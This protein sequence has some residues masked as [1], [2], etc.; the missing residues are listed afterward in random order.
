MVLVALSS[1]GAIAPTMMAMSE[2]ADLINPIYSQYMNPM[3]TYNTAPE[4]ASAREQARVA[5][6]NQKKYWRTWNGIWHSDSYRGC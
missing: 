1:I 5:R 3:Q 6:Y 2:K 4:L